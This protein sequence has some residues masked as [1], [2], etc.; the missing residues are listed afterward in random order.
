MRVKNEKNEQRLKAAQLIIQEERRKRRNNPSTDIADL[1]Q[2]EIWD[3]ID[4]EHKRQREEWTNFMDRG[5]MMD[6]DGAK[7]MQHLETSKIK[8]GPYAL[9]IAEDFIQK[10]RLLIQE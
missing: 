9:K 3:V 7:F 1:I 6:P 8:F 5:A 4:E 2:T 10:Q